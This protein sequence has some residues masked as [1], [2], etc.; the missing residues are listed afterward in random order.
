RVRRC[1]VRAVVAV[2]TRSFNVNAMHFI[3]RHPEHLGDGPSVRINTLSVSP[4]SHHTVSQVRDSARGSYRSMG[5]I[6]P[7]ISSL[8]RLTYIPSAI[9]LVENDMVFSRQAQQKRRKTSLRR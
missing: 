7:R 6:G 2:A 9:V 4:D 1:I 8:H 5:D 3:R